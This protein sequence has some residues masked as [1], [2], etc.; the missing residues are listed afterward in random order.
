MSGGRHR[1]RRLARRAR[2]LRA[3]ARRAVRRVALGAYYR[4]QLR[5]PIEPDLAVFAAYWYRDYSCNPRA[6][7]EKLRELAPW[8]RGVWVIERDRVGRIP[9]GVEHVVSGTPSYY[10]LL[11][12]AKYF[13]NNVNFPNHLVKRDGTVH[14][15]THHGTPLKKMGLDLREAFVASRR[16]NFDRLLRRAARWDYSISSN[17][18][19]TEVWRRA[20]PIPFETLE[21]GYP[22]NDRL[23]TATQAEVARVRKELGIPAGRTAVLYAPTHREYLRGYV[24]MLDVGRVAD[25]LGRDYVI[26]ARAHYLYGP[27]DLRELNRAALVLD[28]TEHESVEDLCLAAD[29]LV[30]DYSAI[31]FDYGV[32][33]RPIV[34]HAPD[35]D[36]YRTLRGTY[37]DLLAEPPGVVTRTDDELVDAFRSGAVWGE[38]AARLRADFRAKFCALDDG[39]AAERVVRRVWL[40]EQEPA[41]AAGEAAE[42]SALATVEG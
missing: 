32:L 26:M 2:R 22:R 28:V 24:E 39:R 41:Q 4:R 14:V 38:E 19:S 30:T 7:Y 25:E 13:V 34:I 11:A 8:I 42:Q 17:T 5:K 36:V 23:A 20:Y 27:G 1:G 40:S 31:M 33:D 21:V 35:W 12:R 18:F 6:I 15:Q 3:R 9:D 29:V 10:R 37:F 16:M